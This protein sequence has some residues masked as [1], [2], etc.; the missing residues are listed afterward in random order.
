SVT[1]QTRPLL[2]DFVRG[3]V[4]TRERELKRPNPD[5]PFT[6]R[7]VAGMRNTGRDS[8][9]D[10]AGFGIDTAD[11]SVV[12]VQRPDSAFPCGKE[13]WTVRDGYPALDKIVHRIHSQQKIGL[14]AGHP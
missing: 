5:G 7:D 11:R 14:R 1:P 10:L 9:L 8:G 2:R 4:D 13:P 12:F 6:G 3:R